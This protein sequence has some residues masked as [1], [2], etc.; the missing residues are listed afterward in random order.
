M[1]TD[2]LIQGIAATAARTNRR[3]DGDYIENGL[4][5]CGKCHTPKQCEMEL[6]G[7]IIKPY[8]MCRCESEEWER[9]RDEERKAARMH[10]LD[11][12]RRT[13]FPDSEM[14]K[15][16]FEADDGQ[17]GKPMDVM[18]R[19]V[20]NFPAMLERG[21]GLLLHGNVG[22]GKSFAAAC[23]ANALIDKG[24]PCM[25][26]NFTRLV[27]TINNQFEGRQKYIDSL[28]DFDLLVIDDLAAER[29]TEFMT[30]QVMTIIDARYRS[31]LPLIVTTNLEPQQLVN[32]DGIGRKRIYSRLLEMCIPV[33]F[34]GADRRT[35][36]LKDGTA[37]VRELLGL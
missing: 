29:D 30:E 19:Y 31:G 15:W 35:S 14:R 23:V 8:C 13:G 1:N 32:P 18:R 28:N 17:S 33:K 11:M 10:R 20:D 36:N 25:M 16:T 26:T 37:E 27:N 22:S 4:L 7:R 24:T 9:Q 12:M 2:T 6:A 34:V 3:N 21:K 5:H